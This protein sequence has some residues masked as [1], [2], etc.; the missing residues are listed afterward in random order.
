ME[1][2]PLFGMAKM[3]YLCP[4]DYLY[5]HHPVVHILFDLHYIAALL[6]TNGNDSMNAGIPNFPLPRR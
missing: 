2:P 1:K 3:A 5:G 4:H 6:Q